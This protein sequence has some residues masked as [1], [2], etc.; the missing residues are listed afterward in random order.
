MFDENVNENDCKLEKMVIDLRNG[1][2][3]KFEPLFECFHPLVRK[4]IRQYRIRSMDKDDIFQEA[5]IIL[6]EAVKH[7]EHERASSF[8]TYYSILLKHRIFS[9]IRRETA[10]KRTSDF[11][12]ISLESLEKNSYF[13]PYEQVNV[14]PEDIIQVNETFFETLDDLS[15]FERDVFCSYLAGQE[16][17]E[18]AKEKSRS[19]Q[20]IQRAYDRC[21]MKFKKHFF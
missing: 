11:E 21:V 4:F 18:I 5:R 8:S 1:D 17:T 10:L 9:L 19:L 2:T 15:K 16:K 7:Y 13:S 6:H 20:Q 12:S 3:T 14:S